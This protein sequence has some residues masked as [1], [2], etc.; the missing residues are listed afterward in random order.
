MQKA[1][2]S[3][4][5]FL[6]IVSILIL[7]LTGFVLAILI[8]YRKNQIAYSKMLEQIKLEHEQNLLS[9]QIEI[10]ENTFQQIS[11]EIHDNINLELTLA[12]LILNTLD[13]TYLDGV[14]IQV[15]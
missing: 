9:T 13:W 3:I 1:T 2:H 6:I 15:M 4:T 14:K 10:Q 12:K 11:R 5:L 8:L 7:L